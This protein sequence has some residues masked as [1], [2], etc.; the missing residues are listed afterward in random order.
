MFLSTTCHG[1]WSVR[2]WAPDRK[3]DPTMGEKKTPRESSYFSRRDDDKEFLKVEFLQKLPRLPS[4]YCRES[5]SKEYLEAYIQSMGE[6]YN[7]YVT[8]C[9][10]KDRVPLCCQILQAEFDK[11]NFSLFRPEKISVI[12]V[13]LMRQVMCQKING[14]IT[15]IGKIENEKKKQKTKKK[16]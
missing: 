9:T 12:F 10:E 14:I 3:E 5:S 2:N 8:K 6:L 16:Q 4:H 11:M 13:W 1:E 7:M 15:L